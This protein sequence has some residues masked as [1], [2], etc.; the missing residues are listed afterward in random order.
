MFVTA[1]G[2]TE[3]VV[4]DVIDVVVAITEP[5]TADDVTAA[6]ESVVT[7]V[8]AVVTAIVPITADDVTAAA[9]S[10]VTGVTGVVSA[11]TVP[12][13]AGESVVTGVTGVVT[14]ITVVAIS[15]MLTTITVFDISS[16]SVA[17][18]SRITV[19]TQFSCNMR[20]LLYLLVQQHSCK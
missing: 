20:S 5:V 16:A 9:E 1:D 13:V 15:M 18:V 12:A 14:A 8:T 7:G 6:G 2:V 19:N 17:A 10:I 11:I 4:T 3:V